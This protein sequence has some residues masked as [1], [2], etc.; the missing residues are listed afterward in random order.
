MLPSL[1]VQEVWAGDLPAVQVVRHTSPRELPQSAGD[2]RFSSNFVVFQTQQGVVFLIT[3]AQI[4]MC[5]KSF[6]FQ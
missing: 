1:T 6:M 4:I 2:S 3:T 5:L